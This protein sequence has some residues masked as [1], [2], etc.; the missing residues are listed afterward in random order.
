[1]AAARQDS[2]VWIANSDGLIGRFEL[3]VN[4]S[5]MRAWARL[6]R[7]LLADESGQD[8]I[9]YGLLTGIVVAIG[10]AVFTSINDKMADAYGDWGTE[11]QT[12]WVPA[13]ALPPEP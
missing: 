3:L 5:S 7:Q 2:G 6:G 13:P 9:E 1:M 8:V 10:V 12:N 4:H 11:I